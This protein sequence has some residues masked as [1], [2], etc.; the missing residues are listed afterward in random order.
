MFSDLHFISNK[1]SLKTN[2]KSKKKGIRGSNGL[3][4]FAHKPAVSR[5]KM[6]VD[7]GKGKWKYINGIFNIVKDLNIA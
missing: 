4:C 6:R 7:Q 5:L 2:S 3:L 1:E